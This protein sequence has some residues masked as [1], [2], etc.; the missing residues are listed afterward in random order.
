[1]LQSMAEDRRI[2]YKA[3]AVSLPV[4]QSAALVML[5]NE[6]VSNAIKHGTGEINITLQ[7]DGQRARLEVY[8]GGPGFSIG[9]DPRQAANTGLELIDS[10]ARWDLKGDV[11]YQNRKEGGA[12]VTVTFPIVTKVAG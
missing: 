10:V 8:D 2:R 1:M 7:R 6:L 9:F 11:S 4:Q 3:E 12:H 5:V